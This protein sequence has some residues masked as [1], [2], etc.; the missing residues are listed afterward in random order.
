[1]T[2]PNQPIERITLPSASVRLRDYQ[3]ECIQAV[4]AYFEEGGKRAGISLATGSGKTVLSLLES[5]TSPYRTDRQA[6]N[7]Y[8]AY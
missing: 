3:E 5:Q 8:A 2:D 4:L 6:G 1:M 7:F